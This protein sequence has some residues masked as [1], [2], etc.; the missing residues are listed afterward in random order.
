MPANTL[1]IHYFA[2]SSLLN[3]AVASPEALGGDGVVQYA[4]LL[5]NS[6]LVVVIV[7]FSA[8]APE[9]IPRGSVRALLPTRT[10]R[11]ITI[12]PVSN[13]TS[14]RLSGALA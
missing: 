14:H 10:Y 5:Y 6:V 3:P 2:C 13:S 4:Y 8:T 9:L 12:V 11:S 7:T 1:G